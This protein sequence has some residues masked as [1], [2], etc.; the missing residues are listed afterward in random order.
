MNFLGHLFLSGEEPRTIVGNFMGD[1]VKGRDLSR[2]GP[3]LERGLRLHRVIDSFTDNHP[4]QQDGRERARHHAGRYASVVMDL[5]YDHLLASH[6][7]EFHPEPLPRYA[8]RMY[9]LLREHGALMP[10][11]TNHLLPYMVKGDWLSSYASM[12]GLA[13]ALDGLSRRTPQ[14]H[15]MK[16]AE[17]VLGEHLEQYTMEFRAF[18]SDIIQHTAVYR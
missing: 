13:R 17:R 5:F 9:D 18:L 3:A 11:R 14:G 10:D 8:A 1:A 15:T 12:D 2:F 4:L 7:S 6:W 16:G